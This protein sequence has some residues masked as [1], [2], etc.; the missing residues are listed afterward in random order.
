MQSAHLTVA[1]DE[2][3]PERRKMIREPSVKMKRSPCFDAMLPSTGS[4]HHMQLAQRA[5]YQARGLQMHLHVS[6]LR[7]LPCESDCP[8]HTTSHVKGLPV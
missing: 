6:K 4:V 7:C 2:P 3:V 5:S 8:D 1:P